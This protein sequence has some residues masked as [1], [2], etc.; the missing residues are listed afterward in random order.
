MEAR[1]S[2][3]VPSD[4]AV[5]GMNWISPVAPL[6]LFRM[7]GEKVS[8][9]SNAI[10]DIRW[11]GSQPRSFEIWITLDLNAPLTFLPHAISGI[12]ISL[13]QCV[14]RDYRPANRGQADGGARC[15]P[16]CRSAIRSFTFC[17][18]LF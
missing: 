3:V 11:L 4:L 16:L 14:L 6:C 7:L 18:N 2:V 17:M 5:D 12:V 1:S 13:L 8:P 15:S 9:V 10:A